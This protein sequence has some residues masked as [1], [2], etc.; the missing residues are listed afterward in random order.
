MDF[1]DG[2]VGLVSK[3]DTNHVRCVR[4]ATLPTGSFESSTVN[5]DV[6]VT[7]TETGLIW[8]KT[9]VTDKSWQQALK[10]CEES[11]YAGFTDW[12]LPNKNELAS[13]VNYEKYNPA[14]DF[15]DMPSEAFCSSSTYYQSDADYAWGVVFGYGYVGIV[16]KTDTSYVRCVR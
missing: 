7:D 4:G 10:Y 15:P 2:Y 13:L 12:R 5:S 1:D 16:S 3:T 8:Q 11:D 9:Y 14:S 6:I